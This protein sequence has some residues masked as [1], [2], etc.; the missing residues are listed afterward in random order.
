MSEPKDPSNPFGASNLNERSS[1][2]ELAAAVRELALRDE[3]LRKLSKQLA[4][5]ELEVRRLQGLLVQV[6]ERAVGAAAD[7]VKP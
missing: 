6:A 7:A 1:P 4:A 5:A 3:T 2:E